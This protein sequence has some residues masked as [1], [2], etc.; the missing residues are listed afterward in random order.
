[1]DKMVVEA[2]CI[3]GGIDGEAGII[4]PPAVSFPNALQLQQA[5]DRKQVLDRREIQADAGDS[6][7]SENATVFTL[8]CCGGFG[9]DGVSVKALYEHRASWTSARGLSQ[10]A[11]R[12]LHTPLSPHQCGFGDSVW[13]SGR[14]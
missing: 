6:P 8:H 5:P 1:M 12:L 3:P 2:D 10:R 4:L 7:W 11:T 9:T 14:I 13:D